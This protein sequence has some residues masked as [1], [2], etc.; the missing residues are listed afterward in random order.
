MMKLPLLFIDLAFA[1]M[2][3]H[4][5]DNSSTLYVLGIFI[6]LAAKIALIWK[7]S[8][9]INFKTILITA[10]LCM[11]GGY[12]GYLVGLVFFAERELVRLC[13]LLAFVFLG[14]AIIIGLHIN[15]PS[16]YKSI[17]KGSAKAIIKK[18]GGDDDDE[19]KEEKIEE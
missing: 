13:I 4:M 1:I 8:S 11:A 16:L 6:I 12:V 10:I 3:M 7:D 15:F 2:L 17:L 14:D 18:M 5:A 9:S 19:I